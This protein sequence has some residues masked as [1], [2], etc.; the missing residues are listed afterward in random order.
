[1]P[2][3]ARQSGVA[4]SFDTPHA[5]APDDTLAKLGG[6]GKSLADMTSLLGLPVPPGFTLVTEACRQYM[7][8]GWTPAL[9]EA[10]R[11]ALEALEARL[12]RRLGDANNPLLLSVRSGSVVSMPGMM[13]TI[14]N[15]GLNPET[16]AGLGRITGD[17]AFA[18]N[19]AGRLEEMFLRTVGAKPPQDSYAQL[20]AAIEAVF[21]SWNSPRARAYRRLEGISEDAGTAVNIQAMVF[22][23]YDDRSGTG[24]VFSRNPSTGE[25]VVFGD[26]LFRAQGEDVVSGAHQ[27]LSVGELARTLP[28]VARQLDEALRRIER[29]YRNLVEVEFTIERGTLWILQ[30]RNGRCS[31]QAAIRIAADMARDADFPLGREEAARRVEVLLHAAPP[32]RRKPGSGDAIAHGLGASPGAV[33]GELVTSWEAAVAAVANG[34]AVILARPET[35][36]SDVEGISAAV[37]II[38]ARGGLASHAAV[39]ARGWGKPAVVGIEDMRVDAEGVS[40]GGRRIA[41]GETVSLDGHSGEVFAGPVEFAGEAG[42]E[43]HDIVAW[44]KA[45]LEETEDAASAAPEPAAALTDDDL[46]VLMTVKGVAGTATLAEILGLSPEATSARLESLAPLVEKLGA[47]MVR[48]S[49]PGRAQGDASIVDHQQALGLTSSKALLS[50]FSG[51]DLALKALVTRW[52][53]REV[54]GKLVANDHSNAAYDREILNGL[55]AIHEDTLAW[56]DAVTPARLLAVYMQRLSRAFEKVAAGRTEYLVSPRVDSYHNVW[57]ELHEYLIRLAGSTREAEE[58]AGHEEEVGRWISR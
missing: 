27:T 34:R 35:S 1:M 55:A 11:R 26:I 5:G 15:V 46:V 21:Q 33:T 36:P 52:Q 50:A 40:L 31:P 12:G 39:V 9:D 43:L 18:A 17:A 2:H 7:S 23:N 28:E 58:Q 8:D 30:A 14:L 4:V 3:P 16:A 42:G 51:C 48:I 20:K 41:V 53:T 56:L 57:F 44:L 6:K 45:G 29:H 47:A 13:D 22:G 49:A 38:T 19:C 25:P 10:V 24:V 37:G 32:R 54:D